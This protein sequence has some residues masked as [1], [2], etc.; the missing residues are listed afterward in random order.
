MKKR[1]M[2]R[3]IAL[4]GLT[5]GLL[6][7]PSGRLTARAEEIVA[8]V[9][10]T[11]LSDTSASILYL[12]TEDGVMEIKLDDDTDTSACKVLIADKRVS[13][14]L[15]HG[16]DGYLHAEKITGSTELAVIRGLDVTTVEG[17]E[18]NIKITTPNDLD[19]AE[20]YIRERERQ[21]S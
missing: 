14:S 6:F 18:R 13:V 12:S 8:T 4:C 1:A 7:C 21:S 10:G 9:Y 20:A 15:S 16:S 11:V 5:A 17:D 2:L 19:L 3:T